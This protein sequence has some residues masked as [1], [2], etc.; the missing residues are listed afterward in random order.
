MRFLTALFVG[1]LTLLGAGPVQAHT[2][3]G[4]ISGLASGIV[5]PF[6]GPDHVLAMVLIG[7]WSSQ[8]AG[9]ALWAVPLAFV[10]SMTI[11]GAVAMAGIAVPFVELA[12]A[13]S[14]LLLGAVIAG[15][16]RAPVAFA[17]LIAAIFGAV[18]GH[19]H[20]TEMPALGSAAAYA[21]GFVLAT[22][23]LH[24]IGIAIGIGTRSVLIVRC[25]GGTAMVAA[26][27]L[28]A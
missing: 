20:G 14:V 27:V 6:T 11:G 12:A 19:A 26:A 16:V 22:M 24:A 10:A 25:L 2:G 9:R 13:L 23:L 3:A 5:H 28:I 4:A 15:R 7:L 18:H 1:A 21:A 8:I 17:M